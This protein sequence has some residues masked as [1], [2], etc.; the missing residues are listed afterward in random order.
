M[1]LLVCFDSSK[2]IPVAIEDQWSV[3]FSYR[4]SV[5]QGIHVLP[6]IKLIF[7]FPIYSVAGA[8]E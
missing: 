1:G 3:V 7:L 5:L 8:R 4:R 6:R 2:L